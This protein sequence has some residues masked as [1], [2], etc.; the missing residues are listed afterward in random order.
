MTVHHGPVDAQTLARVTLLINKTNQFNLT[1]R[2]YT[3]DQVRVMA[4]SA[5]WWCHWY[6]LADR[7]GDHG[8]IGVMLAERSAVP[9]RIDT[10]LM[11]CR[12]L[13]R[14]MEEFMIAN[15]LSVARDAG[16]G[17]VAGQ[18]VATDRNAL[19]SDLYPRMG[20]EPQADAPGQ[21]VF[22]LARSAIRACEF[23]RDG[24]EAP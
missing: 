13:G 12:V 18:Y 14:R 11:S 22:S 3:E 17:T 6:R 7:F 16:V 20:F 1:A 8:L 4:A 24:T 19:V 21:Y 9:W 2:R 10:W 15:L 23:I 5:D